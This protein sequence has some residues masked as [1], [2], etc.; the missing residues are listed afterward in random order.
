MAGKSRGSSLALVSPDLFT[1]IQMSSQNLTLASQGV[2]DF[3]SLSSTQLV[4]AFVDLLQG[5][6]NAL[7]TGSNNIVNSVTGSINQFFASFAT[8]T[9]PGQTGFSGYGTGY[10]YY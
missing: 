4:T 6:L 10:Y 8:L 7:T 2:I 5:T 9:P 3:F 1:P